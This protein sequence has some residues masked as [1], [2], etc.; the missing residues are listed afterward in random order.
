VS[1]AKKTF[2]ALRSAGFELKGI[3]MGEFSLPIMN[4][5]TGHRSTLSITHTSVKRFNGIYDQNQPGTLLG[6]K[7]ITN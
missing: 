1:L 4:V 6:E 3:D 7:I 2:L 5:K